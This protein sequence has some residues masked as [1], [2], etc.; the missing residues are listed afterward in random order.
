[1]ASGR[2]MSAADHA[3]INAVGTSEIVGNAAFHMV[4][5]KQGKINLNQ[6]NIA[7]ANA[8]AFTT[9]AYADNMGMYQTGG[10]AY[11]GAGVAG[12]TGKRYE[13]HQQLGNQHQRRRRE[14]LSRQ[15][16]RICGDLSPIR[17]A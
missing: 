14:L 17:V 8:R 4:T 6:H 9:F 16:G 2:H 3:T 10:A 11:T 1:M 7:I 13:G 15:R 5:Q 12:T